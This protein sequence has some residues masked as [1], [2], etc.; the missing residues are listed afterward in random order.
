MH[1]REE[2][3]EQMAKVS[4]KL[5]DSANSRFGLLLKRNCSGTRGEIHDFRQP[6][7][8]HRYVRFSCRGKGISRRFIF[9]EVTAK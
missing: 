7:G 3:I 8:S 1:G 6:D 4:L 5:T 2:Y 9:E